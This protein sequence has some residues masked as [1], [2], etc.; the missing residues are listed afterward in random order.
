MIELALMGHRF[1]DWY[2]KARQSIAAVCAIK[3]WPEDKFIKV[4]A[5]TSP[6]MSVR[7]NMR[8][9][10]QY[11]ESGVLPKDVTRS[12]RAAL[13][14]LEETDEI[15]GPKTSQFAAA[16]FGADDPIVLDTWMAAAFEIDQKLFANK[17]VREQA[18]TRIR[19]AAQHLTWTNAQTQA[20]IW[21]ATVRLAGRR[22]PM[23]DLASEITLFD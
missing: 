18:E 20:A 11:M 1:K 19:K 17:G 4:L 14:H 9:T 3:G 2:S 21:S 16:L 22:I 13:V 7:R 5:V 8:V 23:M 15:R 12:T 6:R 10:L